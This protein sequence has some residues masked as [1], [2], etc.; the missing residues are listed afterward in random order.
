VRFTAV[1]VVLIATAAASAQVKLVQSN[2]EGIVRLSVDDKPIWT[3]VIKPQADAAK[4]PSPSVG[5]F[6]PIY[7]PAGEV[8]T[9]LA[10]ADHPHHRG[11]FLAFVEVHGSKD[12]DFWG[13]GKPAPIDGRVITHEFVSGQT[14]G[15]G[16]AGATF[17]NAWVAEGVT[18]INESLKTS[19]R[20][21]NGVNV[22]DLTYTLTPT[23]NLT[24]T[25]WAFSGFC[26]RGRGDGE[27]KVFDLTGEVTRENPK[28]TDPS[29]DWPD[30]PWYD[31]VT[32]LPSGKVIG[33]AVLNHP[34]NPPTLWHNH[35]KIRMI[36]PCILAPAT[37]SVQLQKGAPL[38]LKY[39][40]VA[41]DGATPTAT[42]NALAE[43]FRK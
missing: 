34:S 17:N 4:L 36:N 32:A 42:L 41:H 3:Y 35:R 7:T 27:F 18:L 19:T 28:H 31:G 33:M 5:Y 15:G 13:W 10:P 29:T 37:G 11:V 14:M 21:V 38:V 22:I 40:L 30:Q 1:L 12:A 24:L 43:D 2:K 16:A 25:R 39:R 9:D 23:E 8:L 26:Y 20:T 6:H